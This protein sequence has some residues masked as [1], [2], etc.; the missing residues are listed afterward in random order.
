MIGCLVVV[1]LLCGFGSS[2]LGF[3]LV[4]GELALVDLAFSLAVGLL[5]PVVTCILVYALLPKTKGRIV[6]WRRK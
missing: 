4:D 5:G 3:I 6:L 2:V 1:W